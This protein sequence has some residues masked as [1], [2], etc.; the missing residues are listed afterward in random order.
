MG[1]RRARSSR[2]NRD[3]C[4]PEIGQIMKR[5]LIRLSRRYTSALRK[6]LKAGPCASLQAAR[7]LGREALALGLETLAV[8]RMH[9]G[10][11]AA[12]E[13]CSSRPGMS[14]RADTFF[15]ETMVP[16]EQTHASNRSLKQG[17]AQ[18]RTAEGEF[19]RNGKHYAKL[20][21]KS[22]CRQEHLRHVAHQM[23]SA[24][25]VERTKLS[26]ELQDD[27]VQTLLAINVRLL[28]LKGAARGDVANLTKEI[29]S[30]QRLVEQS[31][32]SIHRFA[33]ELETHQHA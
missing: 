8:A 5:R 26:R 14:K 31:V 17:V 12:I 30:T 7:G 15:A 1:Y 3:S 10:A 2:L 27:V 33:H 25:E 22:C 16:I 23:I 13:A 19:Q 24:Q 9:E 4:T 32:E 6:Y 11:L 20:L 18:R 29:A 21:E 28:S